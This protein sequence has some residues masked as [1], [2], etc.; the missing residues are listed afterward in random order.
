VQFREASEEDI[1]K[2]KT[3]TKA[4]E[5]R[6]KVTKIFLVE[7]GP[8]NNVEGSGAGSSASELVAHSGIRRT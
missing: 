1:T 6:R 8:W 3:T 5:V 4:I 2:E 7:N